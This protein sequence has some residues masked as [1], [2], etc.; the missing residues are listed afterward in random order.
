MDDTHS[1][2]TGQRFSLPLALAVAVCFGC[3]ISLGIWQL[4]RLAWKEAL[5]AEI[6]ER[7]AATPVS[8][9]EVLR[10]QRNGDDIE[11][12]R[13]KVDGK[14]L[15]SFERYFY[16][17]D[18]KYGPGFDVYTPFELSGGRG[19][20]FVN[21]GFVPDALKSPSQRAA[22]QVSG[23]ATLTGTVRLPETKRLFTPDNDA[24]KNIWFWRDYDGLVS[25]VPAVAGNG[26]RIPL[27]VAV[28]TPAPGGW[29]KGRVTEVALS[30]RHFGYALTWFG[31]AATLLG[32]Y[33]TMVWVRYRN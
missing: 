33:G 24:D 16:M 15:H 23:I 20:I 29:P 1:D 2:Q 32:V 7:G 26:T 3:L 17:P 4:Q 13:V 18:P 28:E 21:R 11:F 5:I 19:M 10:R 8:L 22:G 12:T 14:F 31:L 25:G 9:D 27:F 30:N 6:S